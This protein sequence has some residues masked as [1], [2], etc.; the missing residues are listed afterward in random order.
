MIRLVTASVFIVLT[1]SLLSIS[2]PPRSSRT[3]SPPIP[4]GTPCCMKTTSP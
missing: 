1:L 3:L 4:R 2:R